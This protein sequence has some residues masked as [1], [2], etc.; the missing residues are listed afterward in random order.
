VTRAVTLLRMCWRYHVDFLLD[1]INDRQ[2]RLSSTPAGI[3][4]G[5]G[6][7]TRER[8][9]LTATARAISLPVPWLSG[10]SCLTPR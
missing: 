8:W 7:R 10:G 4:Y 5:G 6:M 3:V 9:V 1:K 2:K